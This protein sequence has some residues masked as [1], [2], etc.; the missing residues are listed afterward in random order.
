MKEDGQNGVS[1]GNLVYLNQASHILT[2]MYEETPSVQSFAEQQ[3]FMYSILVISL[4][5][6]GEKELV[7]EYDDNAWIIIWTW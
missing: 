2:K 4:Q 6:G 7:K 5:T 1:S 3:S